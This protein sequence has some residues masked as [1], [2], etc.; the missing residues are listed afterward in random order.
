VA[1]DSYLGAKKAEARG[2]LQDAPVPLT[3]DPHSDRATILSRNSPA[4]EDGDVDDMAVATLPT[5][6]ENSRPLGPGA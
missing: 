5:M 2:A 3:R 6:P 1:S 4:D